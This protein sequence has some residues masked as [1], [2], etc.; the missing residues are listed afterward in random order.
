MDKQNQTIEKILTEAL[1]LYAKGVSLHSI[2]RTY[3][4]FTNE[5]EELFATM[6]KL[7][8]EREKIV[9]PQ[10]GLHRLLAKIEN[11][12]IVKSASTV[13][14]FS[15]F[16]QSLEHS[17]LRFVLPIAAIALIT[18]GF[19]LHRNNNQI[20][21]TPMPVN[22]STLTPD[23]TSTPN[24]I[25]STSIKPQDSAI[26]Q[27]V[28]LLAQDQTNESRLAAGNDAEKAIAL[29]SSGPISDPTQSYENKF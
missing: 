8:L 17:N 1:E 11:T 28:A 21:P 9:V 20:T 10:E 18:G 2:V 16:L 7:S 25:A 15:R 13:S 5:I 24:T 29:G 23:T 26:D 12:E 14:P 19:V 27:T 3:P 22:V 6:A 4:E